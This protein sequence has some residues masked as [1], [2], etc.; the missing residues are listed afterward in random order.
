[1]AEDQ[2]PSSRSSLDIFSTYA[3]YASDGLRIIQLS[4][5]ISETRL[6]TADLYLDHERAIVFGRVE[7][8]LEDYL[9]HQLVYGNP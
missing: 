3:S 7:I 8:W 6:Y 4:A 1:M 9:A 2:R 5:P